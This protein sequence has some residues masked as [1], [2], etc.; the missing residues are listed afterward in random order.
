[1]SVVFGVVGLFPWRLTPDPLCWVA[2]QTAD[3]EVAEAASIE[4]TLWANTV[5][6][7]GTVIGVVV[8]TG[9]WLTG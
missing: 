1:M 6:A 4:N 2:G 7:S 3:G 8:Y 9:K 5:V